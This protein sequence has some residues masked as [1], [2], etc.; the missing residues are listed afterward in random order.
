MIVNTGAPWVACTGPSAEA[1]AP[2]VIGAL[3]AHGVSAHA[4]P[5]E[6]AGVILFDEFSS[7]LSHLVREYSDG[8]QKCV[9]AIHASDG[10][11]PADAFWELLNAGASDAFAWN[12]AHGPA[13]I[14][15]RLE[16][17]RQV[18]GLSTLPAVR[19]TLIGESRAWRSMR[20]RIIEI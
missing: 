13:A 1:R 8:G 14:A 3:G 12:P 10:E 2:A 15:A 17:W 6:G 7:A 4:A 20:R 5:P 19:D 16:R 9:V 18:D 11:L